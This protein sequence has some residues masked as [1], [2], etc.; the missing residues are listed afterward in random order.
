MSDASIQRTVAIFA[1]RES[2]AGLRRSV[3]AALLACANV[4]SRIEVLVNGNAALAEAAV[5]MIAALELPSGCGV[6][7]W[8]IR[9]ADK[10][11]AWNQFMHEIAT[12]CTMTF[13]VDGYV[14]L[15]P[16][17]CALI[18]AGLRGNPKALAATGVPTAGKSADALRQQM[19]TS[20]GLHG[21]LYAIRP[22]VMVRLKARGFR[23]PVG[24]YRNDSL[25]GAVFNYDLDPARSTWEP[26]RVLV[27][28]KATWDLHAEPMTLRRRIGMHFGRM[29]RQSQG[30][31]ENRAV[32]DHLSLQRRAP[33]ALPAMVST[34]V[35]DW[36]T[37]HRFDAIRM[38][39]KNPFTRHAYDKLGW[40]RDWAGIETPPELLVVRS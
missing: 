11:H 23:L 32:R 26:A 25:L 1:A 3:Q 8:H 29:L 17:A 12:D 10:A 2:I 40:P 38:F 35:G 30:A 39:L 24:L 37:A 5:P 20:G 15:R 36:V 13:F 18:E 27:H 22:E 9:F 31:L 34:L 6:R 33:E 28:P 21:N 14:L 16:D 7:L 4:P 19:L